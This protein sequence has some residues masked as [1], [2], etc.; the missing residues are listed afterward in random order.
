MSKSVTMAANGLC[1]APAPQG[2]FRLNPWL[3]LA[4]GFGLILLF[5]FGLG[6]L[7]KLIPGAKRMARVIDDRGLRATAIYY[8]DFEEPA[9]GSEYIRDC[10]DYPSGGK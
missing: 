5:I 4:I 10:L 1:G 8:T 2:R 7:S 3:K 6:S 9:E